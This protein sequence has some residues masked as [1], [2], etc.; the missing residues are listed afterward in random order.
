MCAD[1]AGYVLGFAI[2]SLGFSVTVILTA[3]HLGPSA[4]LAI[5]AAQAVA[6]LHKGLWTQ[7][8]RRDREGGF[9]TDNS[10]SQEP[11]DGMSSAGCRG[12]YCHFEVF[13]ESSDIVIAE[14]L[15]PSICPE[16]RCHAHPAC[17]ITASASSQT[18]RATERAE[19]TTIPTDIRL[20]QFT[21][22]ESRSRIPPGIY[23]SSATGSTTY[24]I[25][26]PSRSD[27]STTPESIVTAPSA[28]STRAYDPR[29][30]R[31]SAILHRLALYRYAQSDPVR[32]PRQGRLFASTGKDGTGQAGPDASCGRTKAARATACSGRGRGS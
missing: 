17:S 18:R 23:A 29:P 31:P 6:E 5:V 16:A 11:G 9:R 30:R 22:R 7:Y 10:Q 12:K 24:G 13:A 1:V 14:L 25:R 19:T 27:A 2:S 28:I 4:F 15:P 32:E 8:D 21:S 26:P 3:S 20:A